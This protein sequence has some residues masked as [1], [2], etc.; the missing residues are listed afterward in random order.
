MKIKNGKVNR[1]I[2]KIGSQTDLMSFQS[3]SFEMNNDD[4]IC[5]HGCRDIAEYDNCK[6]IVK[7]DKFLINV[8]GENL[9][10]E[11]FSL[12]L[13]NICGNI[14]GIELCKIR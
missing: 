9:K 12:N 4:E 6:I 1:F 14:N 11:K 2:N 5:V 13:T 8:M 7:T 10:L 3:F